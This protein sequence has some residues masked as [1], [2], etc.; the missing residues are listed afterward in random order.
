MYCQMKEPA[1]ARLAGPILLHDSHLTTVSMRSVLLLAALAS[2]SCATSVYEL[3]FY[4]PELLSPR[5][6]LHLTLNLWGPPITSMKSGGHKTIVRCEYGVRRYYAIGVGLPFIPLF[7][8]FGDSKDRPIILSVDHD[9]EVSVDL[10]SVRCLLEQDQTLV[11]LRSAGVEFRYAKTKGG[12]RLDED[13]DPVV[14]RV[15]EYLALDATYRDSESFV[16]E[17]PIVGPDE[18]TTWSIH[19]VREGRTEWDDWGTGPS[20]YPIEDLEPVG[21]PIQE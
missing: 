14:E 3:E 9:P 17:L 4:R 12:P 13:G 10:S 21:T 11:G 1:L 16:L 15:V 5:S 7:G 19:F 2:T 6:D 20:R 18:S 8:L